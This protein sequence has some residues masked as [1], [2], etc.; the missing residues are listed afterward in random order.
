MC[1][2]WIV[3]TYMRMGKMWGV[4]PN[5]TAGR[6]SAAPKRASCM[7]VLILLTK[8]GFIRAAPPSPVAKNSAL[9]FHCTPPTWPHLSGYVSEACPNT[10]LHHTYLPL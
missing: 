2:R 6:P 3:A 4:S 7:P 1:A 9:L 5:P 8:R 10:M